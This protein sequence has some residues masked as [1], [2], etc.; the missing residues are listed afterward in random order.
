MSGELWIVAGS[1]LQCVLGKRVIIGKADVGYRED[2]GLEGL[3]I[4]HTEEGSVLRPRYDVR[5]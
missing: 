4:H 2:M 3:D 1:L 5:V